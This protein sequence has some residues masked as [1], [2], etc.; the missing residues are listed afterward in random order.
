MQCGRSVGILEGEQ[1]PNPLFCVQYAK[2]KREEG[3]RSDQLYHC[4][5]CRNLMAGW[6]GLKGERD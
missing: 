4:A 2:C 3:W 6:E 1:T 5:E